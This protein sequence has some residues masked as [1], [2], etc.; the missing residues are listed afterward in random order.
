MKL[1]TLGYYLV[2]N[3]GLFCLLFLQLEDDLNELLGEQHRI[4][5]S[6]QALELTRLMVKTETIDDRCT[7]L[8]IVRVS[9]FSTR[10]PNSSIPHQ[11]PD[12]R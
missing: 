1:E 12:S 7:L 2:F 11:I 6:K 5:T 10:S 8:K 3:F 4:S 9:Y